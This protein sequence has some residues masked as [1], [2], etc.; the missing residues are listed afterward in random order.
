MKILFMHN[1][2]PAQYRRIYKYIAQHHQDVRMAVA[3]LKT[4]EQIYNMPTVHFEPHREV[5]KSTHPAAI[6]TEAS[7][8]MGQAALSALQD[9]KKRGLEPDLICAHSGWGSSLFIKDV[10]P[11]AKLI[12]YFEWYYDCHGKDDE[13]LE[14]KHCSLD[15]ELSV[16]MKNTPILH[17]LAAMDW[18]QCPTRFQHNRFPKQFQERISVLHDGVDIDMFKPEDPDEKIRLKVTD[19]KELTSDDE[20]ISY[21]ARGME[22]YRGFPQFM[23]AVSKLQKI[24]PHLHVVILG[25]DRVA[26]GNKRKDGRTF[27]QWA[28]DEFDFDHSRLHMMDLQ[29]VTY[30]RDLVKITKA[31]IYLTVPFVLSWSLLETMGAG[32]LLIGSDTPPVRELITHGKNGL[33][34]DFFDVDAQVDLINKVLNKPAEYDVLRMA[35]RKTIVSKYATRDILP[36]QWLLMQSVVNGSQISG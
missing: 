13:F 32:A 23:E 25:R 22:E 1:N 29:P 2:F 31:H 15:N 26:Y 7:V 10:F 21:V 35:A 27:K 24:R 16:R 6:T 33:L 3:T 8:L 17:D 28:M 5:A 14:G 9:F 4:N 19:G 30:F 20:V 36:K 11:K 18:G 12:S 34:V